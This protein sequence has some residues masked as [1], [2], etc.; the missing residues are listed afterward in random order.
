MRAALVEDYG[1]DPV[2]GDFGEPSAEPGEAVVEVAAAGLNPVDVKIAS[3]T[4]PQRRPP[5]PYVVGVEGVGTL[6][7]GRRVYFDAPRPP[8]GALAERAPVDMSKAIP[9]PDDFDEGVAVAL[10]VAGMAAWLAL[11]WRA[12]LREGERV[13][14]LGASGTVGQVAVQAAKLLGGHVVAAAR[15]DEAL[16]RSSEQG[17]DATVSL[18]DPETMEE[19]LRAAAPEGYDVIVDPL[20]GEPARAAMEAAATGARMVQLGKSAGETALIREDVVRGK[21]LELL[22]HTNFLVPPQVKRDAYL[23]MVQH[24]QKGELDVEVERYPLDSVGAAWA[25]QQASPG[26]KLVVVP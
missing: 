5:L 23:R 22:G 20:W 11:E 14:V 19:A 26:R 17:A 9:L 12:K 15:S 7:D 25:A 13:L 10:G 8:F 1:R 18:R 3:G 24:V 16:A 21:M 2:V 6:E 4:F